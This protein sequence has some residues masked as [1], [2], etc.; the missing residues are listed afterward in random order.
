M[1]DGSYK[2]STEPMSI[3]HVLDHAVLLYRKSFFSVLPLLFFFSIFSFSTYFVAFPPT[4]FEMWATLIHEYYN[5]YIVIQTTIVSILFLAIL[6]RLHAFTYNIP[7]SCLDAISIALGKLI[8]FLISLTIQGVIVVFMFLPN[9]FPEYHFHPMAWTA[10]IVGSI[11]FAYTF[12]ALLLL[13]THKIN[14]IASFKRSLAIMDGCFWRMTNFYSILF[15]LYLAIA[16]GISLLFFVF[17]SF[18]IS[19]QLGVQAL[20]MTCFGGLIYSGFI[21]SIHDLELRQQQN[22]KISL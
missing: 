5:A 18:G 15:A 9:L 12:P 20:V 2:L 19:L 11:L 13:A 21:A 10:S 6:Y 16:L 14:F 3:G 17:F 4:G 22:H 1:D 7:C 8:P